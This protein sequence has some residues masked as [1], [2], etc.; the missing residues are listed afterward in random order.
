MARSI[1]GSVGLG[2]VNRKS[3]SMTVQ[4]LLNNVSPEDGG[5]SPP[6]KV[7]GLPWQKTIAAI[8]KFQTAQCGFATPDGRVG[9][10]GRTLAKLNEFEELSSH[11]AA[12]KPGRVFLV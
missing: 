9:A 1:S 3:D 11:V 5:P 10:N 12:L 2:G 6:L 8:K 7:D 4:E